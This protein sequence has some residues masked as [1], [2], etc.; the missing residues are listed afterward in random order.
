M[1]KYA[2]INRVT[3][4]VSSVCTLYGSAIVEDYT[5]ISDTHFAKIIPDDSDEITFAFNNYWKDESFHQKPSYPLDG[6]YYR[7][8][9]YEWVLDTE[10]LW[11]EIR[12][13]REGELT[14]SDWTQSLD[15]PFSAEEKTA[16]ATY[17]QALRDIPTTYS[18]ARSEDDITWPTRPS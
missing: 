12:G 5:N 8:S 16:W 13:R 2:Y 11:N 3:G 9:N 15:A 18:D 17:R 10:T 14:G 6:A 7:W 1:K 4:E